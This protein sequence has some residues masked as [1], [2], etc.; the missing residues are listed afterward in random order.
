MGSRRITP[1]HNQLFDEVLASIESGDGLHRYS[2]TD[3]IS[4]IE[5]CENKLRLIAVIDDDGH[6]LNAKSCDYDVA[7]IVFSA[8]KSELIIRLGYSF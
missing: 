2:D 5:T 3:L 4:V 1:S 7:A 8:V 6:I